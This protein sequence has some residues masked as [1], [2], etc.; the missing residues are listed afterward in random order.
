VVSRR[1]T[2]TMPRRG[3]APSSVSPPRWLVGQD[4]AEQGLR[5][6][7]WLLL[8]L[9]GFLG[10]TFIFAGLQKLANPT[11]L[12]P[13]NRSSVLSQIQTLQNSSP[14]GPLLGLSAHAPTLVGLLIAF[15]ELAVGVGALLGLWTKLAA[16][17]GAFLALTFFL[18]VSWNTTPYYYGSDIVFLFAWL[19]LV[20]FGAGG[21]LSVD[22]WLAAKARQDTGLSPAP[23][24]VAVAVPRLR[25]LCDAADTCGLGAS[26]VCRRHPAC[27]VFPVTEKLTAPLSEEL[28]RRTLLLGAR[29]AGLV[30]AAAAVGGGLTAFIGRLVGGTADQAQSS[31]LSAPHSSP[32]AGAGHT[33]SGSPSAGSP[34]PG[35]AIGPASAVP[36]GHAAQF[37][38]PA[39]GGPAWLVHPTAGMFVAFS[40]VCTHAGCTIGFDSASLEF[41]CPCHGGTFNAKTGQV[42]AGPPPS[43]LP[44]I[45]VHVLN[46]QVRVD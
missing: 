43:P 27:P 6:P 5:Q 19:V 44:G 9:R 31:L 17:G 38:D 21:V 30:A 11:Y 4:W 39:S 29:T 22:G 41:I 16:V 42:L 40:A 26:G 12:D 15:G 1:P 13:N 35:T 25:Q 24:T 23:A 7:G 28:G 32:K 10:V 36:V 34:M 3:V 8:P 14:I 33:K 20:G 2:G 46:G 18:T 45:P 37:T